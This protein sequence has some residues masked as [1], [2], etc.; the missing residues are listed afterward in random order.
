MSKRKGEEEGQEA[1]DE[2][3]K[4]EEPQ[5]KRLRF[6]ELNP[7]S[8]SALPLTPPPFHPPTLL[9]PPWTA[10]ARTQQPSDVLR[11]DPILAPYRLPFSSFSSSSPSSSWSLSST[12]SPPHKDL[13]MASEQPQSQS[14][15]DAGSHEWRE[16]DDGEPEWCDGKGVD[17]YPP[18]GTPS[19]STSAMPDAPSLDE[20][21]EWLESED[22]ERRRAEQEELE[23]EMNELLDDLK[24]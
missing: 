19:P 16:V 10:P 21:Y 4:V 14:F 20:V 5:M 9:A 24:L 23:R 13:W 12:P 6:R 8:T 11:V 7:T 3:K 18:H 22:E 1:V 2:E 17:L 15:A